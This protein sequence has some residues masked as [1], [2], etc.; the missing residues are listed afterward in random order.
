[1]AEIT[2]STAWCRWCDRAKALLDRR[3]IPW[4]EVDVELEWSDDDR[5]RLERISGFRSVPQIFVGNTHLGG[6]DE[7]AKASNNGE[8]DHLVQAARG[9]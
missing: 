8:L 1:M 9:G 5:V 7:L 6:Y 4:R 3:G 2:I